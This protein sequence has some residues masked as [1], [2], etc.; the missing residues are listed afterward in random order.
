MNL[1]ESCAAEVRELHAFIQAWMRGS[2]P[3]TTQSFERFADSLADTFVIVHT[4][5]RSDDKTSIT[6]KVFR[7]HGVN[8]DDFT[9]EI[10][11]IR[12]RFAE[13][14]WCMLTYEEH[15]SNAGD[16]SA[17]LS[18]VLFRQTGNRIEWMHLHETRLSDG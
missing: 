6:E 18:S 3:R 12:V 5:G 10:R 4:S 17:R 8:P 7:A 16:N 11:D 15:Q 9:I 13:R 14:P 2:L 1:E